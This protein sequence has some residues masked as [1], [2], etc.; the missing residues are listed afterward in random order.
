METTK[1]RRV[2]YTLIELL[3]V[4]GIIAI[5]AAL[6]LPSL[7]QARRLGRE[8]L[9]LG[10]L[11]QIGLGLQSYILN[12]D[13]WTLPNTLEHTYGGSTD[14]VNFMVYLHNHEIKS[15][16]NV[17]ECPAAYGNP[18]PP[19]QYNN[20]EIRGLKTLAKGSYIQNSVYTWNSQARDLYNVNMGTSVTVTYMNNHFRGWTGGGNAKTP[21]KISRVR[22][23]S[24]KIYV[25][26]AFRK[27][28]EMTDNTW[29]SD[30]ESLNHWLETDWG[31]LPDNLGSQRRDVGYHHLR[32]GFNVLFGDMH[33]ETRLRSRVEEWHAYDY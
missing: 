8:M 7:S 21:I 26:D 18:S 31:P 25:A 17:F 20:A 13:G 32:T 4:I 19:S 30:V 3:F 10:N 15:G 27:P 16:G 12:H 28:V 23:F 1:N 22:D 2:D 33:A 9:C 29:K 5:L 14:E 6:L 11:K 24:G